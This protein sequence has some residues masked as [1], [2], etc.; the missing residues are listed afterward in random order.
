MTT[1][2]LATINDY[3]TKD[4]KQLAFFTVNAKYQA[5]YIPFVYDISVATARH[6]SMPSAFTSSA[7]FVVG[8]RLTLIQHAFNIELTAP[9]Q[10]SVMTTLAFVSCE[11]E[12]NKKNSSHAKESHY[13]NIIGH[14]PSGGSSTRQRSPRKAWGA[15]AKADAEAATE[16]E[17]GAVSNGPRLNY[18]LVASHLLCYSV[19]LFLWMRISG[20]PLT[21][22]HCKNLPLFSFAAAATGNLLLLLLLLCDLLIC[23]LLVVFE[24]LR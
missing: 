16:V 10:C 23:F 4:A 7:D 14:L 2:R 5:C 8:A 13:H 9:T 11:E 12:R 17:A 15:G 19:Y 22:S 3:I 1:E 24:Y 6:R 21:S 18:N 20:C